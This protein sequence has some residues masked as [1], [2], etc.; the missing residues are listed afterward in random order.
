M[1]HSK[2]GLLGLCAVALGVVTMSAGSAQAALAWLVLDGSGSNPKELKASLLSKTDSADLTLLTKLLGKN[3]QSLV[4]A[5]NSLGS[6]LGQ[7][8]P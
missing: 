6:I 5:S 8:A 7:V 1:I 2:L 3:S 4:L